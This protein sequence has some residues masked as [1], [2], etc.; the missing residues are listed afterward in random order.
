MTEI[1]IPSALK[2]LKDGFEAARGGL[3]LL[4]DVRMALSPEKRAEVEKSI[5]GAEEQIRIAEVQIAKAIGFQICKCEFPG[6]PMLKVG[7]KRSFVG[8]GPNTIDLAVHECPR[9]LQTDA[10][11]AIYTRQAPERKV[12]V[13]ENG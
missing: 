2:M 11:G 1:D 5:E 13:K 6:T 3:G 9:C 7:Y 8:R 12:V 4:K 10:F